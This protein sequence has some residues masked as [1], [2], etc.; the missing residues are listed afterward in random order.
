MKNI[1][2]I[3]M[4]SLFP[5]LGISQT[6]LKN[7]QF[8]DI[9]LGTFDS[10]KPSNYSFSLGFGKY[11]KKLNAKGFE[12]TYAK[13]EAILFSTTINIDQSLPVEHIILSYKRGFILVHNVNNTASISII[14]K[15][16][17]GYELINKNNKYFQEYKLK[18]TSD[19]ILG[20]GI[21]PEIQIQNLFLNVNSNLNFIS[22][23]QKFTFFPTIKYRL[24]L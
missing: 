7:Q 9:G 8:I 19:Y 17:V 5:C 11:N 12:I 15:A 20:I 23:Y 10:L 24:N 4:I 18:S 16:T 6:H 3:M 1:I 13:K 2:I 21:S 14:G 22:K